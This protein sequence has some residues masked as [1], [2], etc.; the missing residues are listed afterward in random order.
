MSGRGRGTLH[1]LMGLGLAF[2]MLA[3]CSSPWIVQGGLDLQQC[4]RPSVFVEGNTPYPKFVENFYLWQPPHG[5]LAATPAPGIGGPQPYPAYTVPGP[6]SPA[7]PPP[8]HH[9]QPDP[10]VNGSR[11]RET[12]PSETTA[13]D[14]AKPPEKKRVAIQHRH[15]HH[16]K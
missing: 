13:T 14:D 9:V 3:G 4:R 1:A 7:P 5:S 11:T 6:G 8:V 2:S 15:H 12:A 10:A 16:H